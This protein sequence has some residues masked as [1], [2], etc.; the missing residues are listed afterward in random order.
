MANSPAVLGLSKFGIVS[1]FDFSFGKTL[2]L[3][4]FLNLRPGT[5]FVVEFISLNSCFTVKYLFLKL[6]S[7][8]NTLLVDFVSL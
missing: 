3:L 2:V 7:A 1:I 8:F 5:L 6:S 4:L